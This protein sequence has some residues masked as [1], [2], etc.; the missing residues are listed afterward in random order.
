MVVRCSSISQCTTSLSWGGRARDAV[1]VVG[2]YNTTSAPHSTPLRLREASKA[3]SKQRKLPTA[4]CKPYFDL[5]NVFCFQIVR[6]I[7]ALAKRRG[8]MPIAVKDYSWKETEGEVN[9]VLPLKGV[10][11]SKAD[12]LSTE[13]YIKVSYPPY[14]FEVYLYADVI[15]E[16]CTARVGNGIIEFRLI[17][18]EGGLWGNLASKETEDKQALGERRAEAVEKVQKAAVEQAEARAKKKREEE[19]F[20]IREQ[21]KLEQAQRERIEGEKQEERDRANRELQRWKEEKKRQTEQQKRNDSVAPARQAGK[22]PKKSSS[23][24]WKTES[25]EPLKKTKAPPPRKSGS[26]QV[27]FT[28]RAF[29]TAAR[30][31]REAE[32]QEWLAKQAAARRITQP[33]KGSEEDVNERNPEFLKDRGNNFFR[34]KNYEAAV[35]VFSKA[36]SLNPSL[37]QLFANRAACYLAM[38]KLDKCISDCCRALELYYP[39][40]PSNQAARAKV[41]A[42]R[43]SAYAQSNQLHLAVQDYEAAVQL[44]PGDKR[45]SDDCQR[46]KQAVLDSEGSSA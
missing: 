17:K 28:P 45:L 25:S 27:H 4:T 44:V 5:S 40:V 2:R 14:L 1:P 8:G 13:R 3:F 15:E 26:I 34:A 30:E 39:V 35:D 33:A 22:A 24:I 19:Q 43:G 32:E 9:I 31:S 10:K 20:A 41:F 11:G 16:Q 29:P 36:V 38:G 23:A 6:T 18:K 37:P 42:R 7:R 46:L 12:I 21:M